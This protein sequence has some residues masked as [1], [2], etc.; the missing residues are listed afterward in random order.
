LVYCK[1]NKFS[2]LK[3]SKKFTSVVTILN[4]SKNDLKTIKKKKNGKT[5]QNISL[6]LGIK[7]GTPTFKIHCTTNFVTSKNLTF[8]SK[9]L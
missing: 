4:E 2:K 1:N 9:Y 5:M 6:W 3:W 8:H 7:S